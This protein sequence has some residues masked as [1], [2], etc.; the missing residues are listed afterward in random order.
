MYIEPQKNKPQKNKPQHNA[1]RIVPKQNSHIVF[2]NAIFKI[3]KS[4]FIRKRFTAQLVPVPEKI[5]EKHLPKKQTKE[6]NFLPEYLDKKEPTP[7]ITIPRVLAENM[8]K[9]WQN[10]LIALLE[11]YNNT[12]DIPLTF[13]A[14]TRDINGKIT[15]TPDWIKN[16]KTPDKETID[17]LK[18]YH[19]YKNDARQIMQWILEDAGIIKIEYHEEHLDNIAKHLK[20]LIKNNPEFQD[21]SMLRK[22]ALGNLEPE[23]NSVESIKNIDLALSEYVN[24][25]NKELLNDMK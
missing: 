16:H 5:T 1:N 20:Q 6:K 19:F 14:R 21:E 24:Y 9:K 15:K 23:W 17:S 25:I 4:D 10:R 13:N 7:F 11:E 12:W 18:S 8:P 3:R 22:L 2:N